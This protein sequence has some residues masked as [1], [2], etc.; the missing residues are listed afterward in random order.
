MS[1]ISRNIVANL[2]GQGLVLLMT[3]GGTRY[4]F[5][6]LGGD[7]LRMIIF[8]LTLA[9]VLRSVLELGVC[10]LV[11]REVAAHRTD[12]PDYVKDV[13]RTASF[14]YWLVFA[15]LT[16]T[17]WPLAP[18]IV[19]HWIHLKTIDQAVAIRVIR[20]LGG[21]AFLSVPRALYASILRGL[22][23]MELNNGVELVTSALQ[24]CGTIAIV[25]LG[26]SLVAVSCWVAGCFVL[27][28]LSYLTALMQLLPSGAFFP[29]WVSSVVR[30]N[31]SFSR[32][33]MWV[34]MLSLA[35][36]ESDKILVSIFLPISAT[37]YYGFAANVTNRAAL[38][39]GSIAQ[40]AFPP[41]SNAFSESGLS[42]AMK[43]YRKLHDLLC[44]CTAPIFAGIAFVAPW[45]FTYMFDARVARTLIQP[46][47]LLCIANYLN[48]TLNMPYLMS[49]ACGK[50]QIAVKSASMALCITLP[51]SIVLVYR[52]GLSGAGWSWVFYQI[53]ACAY[54]VPE[55]C[56]EC[57]QLPLA[58]WYWHLG[59][60]LILV[61]ATYGLSEALLV[62]WGVSS[63]EASIAGYLVGSIGFAIGAYVLV[64]EELWET[65]VGLGR[66]SLKISRALA[67]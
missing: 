13:I 37:G 25:A 26:G 38:V 56:Q 46:T 1:K 48:A 60:I 6:G 30:R 55:F 32:K 24:Q 21:A 12:E 52:F 9:A 2:V 10:S 53:F 44:F 63:L 36:L 59:R 50:P 62:L 27:S 45:L 17:I 19:R 33:M 35:H 67:T 31:R 16:V 49:L 7:A 23:R 66:H 41:L 43:Q 57:L 29:G 51:A 28:I 20:I 15:V 54:A 5:R 34:S 11:V 58:Q 22:E 61:A 40:A 42:S 64:G 65:L 47:M 3:F 18:P 39:T 8:M 14:T 4:V